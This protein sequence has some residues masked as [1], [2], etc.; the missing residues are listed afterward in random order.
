MTGEVW[1]ISSQ[2]SLSFTTITGVTR[3]SSVRGP[4]Y[5]PRRSRQISTRPSLPAE[6]AH[7]MILPPEILATIFEQL[8]LDAY[9]DP[10]WYSNIASAAAGAPR[11]APR[12]YSWV[13]VTEV[14]KHW[15]AVALGSPSLWSYIVVSSH[16]G[17]Q[18]MLVR[19]QATPLH[20]RCVS[21]EDMSWLGLRDPDL[22]LALGRITDQFPRVRAL[23]ISTDKLPRSLDSLYC[24]VTAAELRSL[25]IP[26]TGVRDFG[27]PCTR[28]PLPVLERLAISSP[29]SVSLKSLLRKSLKHLTLESRP[30]ANPPAVAE[31]LPLLEAIRELPSL[32]SLVLR[33]DKY[34]GSLEAS[35]H[36]SLPQLQTLVVSG[37][38]AH[39]ID[40]LTSLDIPTTASITIDGTKNYRRR[41]SRQ[42]G[43]Y[44][45]NVAFILSRS[46]EEPESLITE[47]QGACVEPLAASIAVR[48]GSTSFKLCAWTVS[49]SSKVLHTPEFQPHI[50]FT[51]PYR[52]SEVHLE[53]LFSRVSLRHVRT[54]EIGPMDLLGPFGVPSAIVVWF[55]IL[56]HMQEVRTLH[57]CSLD[58]AY[59]W[60]ALLL[61]SEFADAAIRFLKLDTLELCDVRF[62]L[63]TQH[64]LTSY[65]PS[66]NLLSPELT[67]AELTGHPND[68][69]QCLVLRTSFGC[70][71]RKLVIRRAR[72]FFAEDLA[73]LRDVRAAE[74]IEWDGIEQT[75]VYEPV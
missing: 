59:F 36:I 20:V 62:R 28:W 42:F 69:L 34:T 45:S 61:P 39:C 6:P 10:Y 60:M 55:K 53:S 14:C 16:Q 51:I 31:S 48:D 32:H 2:T 57:I 8:A 29:L 12:I 27:I 18:C 38:S 25:P 21:F 68:F 54:L 22:K 43:L 56:A 40:V 71:V 9:Y 75:D 73:A 23:E 35:R 64:E 24:Q 5:L 33:L 72:N 13:R 49:D 4:R 58:N 3:V 11:R 66:D 74:H 44:A 46:L 52:E 15:R 30:H 65:R 50:D 19:S 47:Y 7:I 37:H 63:P 1:L 70:G 67:F 41:D 26:G 17:V